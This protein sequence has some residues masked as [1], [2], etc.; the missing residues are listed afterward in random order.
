MTDAELIAR[1][2]ELDVASRNGVVVSYALAELAPQLATALEAATARADAERTRAFE[3]QV[4]H[5]KTWQRW[6]KTQARA[7][8]AEAKLKVA[9]EALGVLLKVRERQYGDGFP[10]D[11]YYIAA[12]QQKAR[13][14][15]T[16]LEQ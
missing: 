5:E 6:V 1:V 2:R 14:A 4:E 3:L 15:L 11:A 16:Q 7:D 13:A 9:R 8:A 12:A 10:I